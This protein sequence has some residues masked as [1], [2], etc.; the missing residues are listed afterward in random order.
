M[1]LIINFI[2]F[3]ITLFIYIHINFHLKINNDLE[4]YDTDEINKEKLEEICDLKQPLLFK[5]YVEDQFN[6]LDISNILLNYSKFD[7]N[8]RN[9]DEYEKSDTTLLPLSLKDGVKLFNNDISCSYVS[10]FNQDFIEE[11]TLLKNFKTNDLF[12]RPYLCSEC[13]YDIIL[14]TK[15][16]YTPLRYELNYRNFIYVINGSVDIM[17]TIP[18]NIKYLDIIK[19]YEIFEFRSKLNPYNNDH[20]NKLEKVKF[21]NIT[22]KPGDIIYIPFKWLYTIK[23]NNE[24]TLVCNSKYKVFMNTLAIIPQ[25]FYNFLYRQNLKFNF[26]N[27]IK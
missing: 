26:L 14:G 17:L 9:I 15:N 10:E 8:I 2:I 4:I 16:S 27:T 25:I 19:D 23:F 24:H 21:L 18:N 1:Q 11:T 7:I 22:L 6:K 13:S 12:L 3:L 5:H 20:I